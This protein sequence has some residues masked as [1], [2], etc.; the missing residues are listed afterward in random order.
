[1]GVLALFMTMF[2]QMGFSAAAVRN[3]T[4][5]SEVYGDG[6]KVSYVVMEYRSPIDARSLGIDTYDVEGKQVARLYTNSKAEKAQQSRKGKF[7]IIELHNQVVLTQ[8]QPQGGQ[9]STASQA[10]G[11]GRQGSP[12]GGIVA[13]NRP[14]RKQDPFP[15]DV[16][17]TQHR[18]IKTCSGKTILDRK[19][20]SSRT[21]RTLI[22]DDFK[23]LTFTD[24]KTGVTLRYNLFVPKNYDARKQYPLVLFMHDASGANQVDNYTLLQGNG[25]TVWASPQEQAKHPCLVLA[26]QYDE[27]V[28]DDNF[29]ATPSAEATIGLLNYLKSAYSIDASRIYTTGQSMGCMMSYLFM[30]T[31]PEMFASGYLVAGQWDA[32][33]IAPMAVK[34]LWLVSCTGDTKSTAGAETA[35]KLW[36]EAGARTARATWPLDTTAVVRQQEIA[37]LRAQDATIRFSQ[38][39]GGWHNGT[40]RVAYGFVGIRDWL[41]EQHQ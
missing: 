5:V 4:A 24:A 25:A 17:V 28:V 11:E 18:A 30:S 38:L 2:P 8:S 26:P 10:G 3:I 15:G 1:M 41:F 34:P 31:H 37:A 20:M 33:V 7:V 14:D 12:A 22:A 32:S 21:K 23:Q 29:K 19:P 39:Q 13:G 35:L 9:H 6:A 16:T 40:W 27:I 36:S